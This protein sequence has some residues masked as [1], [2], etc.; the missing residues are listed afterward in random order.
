MRILY[1]LPE[2]CGQKYTEK[3]MIIHHISTP[4]RCPTMTDVRHSSLLFSLASPPLQLSPSPTVA[5]PKM[6]GKGRH[7]HMH[8]C[9]FYIM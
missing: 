8:K 4:D 2:Y 3:K 6:L 7:S 9:S 1:F 5:A